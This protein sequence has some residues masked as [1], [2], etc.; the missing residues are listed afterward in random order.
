MLLRAI[1]SHY[2]RHPAQLAALWLILVLATALWTAVWTLTQ[3]ARD[4]MMAGEA[5]LGAGQQVIRSDGRPVSVDDFVS[6]RRLGLC[7]VPWLEVASAEARGRLVGID[8]LAM[9]CATGQGIAAGS[10]DSGERQLELDGR[11]FVDIRRAAELARAG[12]PSTFRL[13]YHGPG[14]HLADQLPGHVPADRVAGWQLRPNP[15]G[16]TTGGLA[17]SFLLNLDA[18]CVLVILVTAL[19]IRSVYTLGLAQ[20]RD[21]FALLERYGVPGSRVRRHLLTEL[22]LLGLLG[23]M[24]GFG[25]GLWLANLLAGGFEAALGGLFET[26]LLTTGNGL[27]SLGVVL[28][29]MLLVVFWCG[30][31]LL[32]GERKRRW[33][34]PVTSGVATSVL[35]L[36]GG[37]LVLASDELSWLFAG[38]GLLLAGIG[39]LTPRVLDQ[40]GGTSGGNPLALW[41]R[42]ETAVLI[43][44]LALPLV[45][46]QFAAATVIAVQALVTTFED[47]FLEWLDQRLAGDLYVEVPEGQQV[48]AVRDLLEGHGA[49]ANWYPTVTGEGMAGRGGSP[50]VGVDVRGTNPASALIRQWSLLEAGPDPWDSLRDQ[51]VM[52]NEQLALRLDLAP[53]DRLMLQLAGQKHPA[54]VAGIYADYGSPAGEVLLDAASLPAA[55]VAGFRSVVIELADDAGASGR[56]SLESAMALA[57]GV[58]AL[59]VRDN[60]TIRTFAIRLFDQTFRLTRAISVLTLGLAA[61]SLLLTGWVVL[62]SRVWY[63]HLLSV[64]GLTDR[65]RYCQIVRLMLGLLGRV[66]LMALPVGVLLTWILVA[67]INP[68]AFGWA[69]PMAVYPGYWLQLLLLL[70]IM[71]WLAAWLA[72]RG[73]VRAPRAAPA[74]QPGG[75]R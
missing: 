51:G 18:L 7:V 30:L 49:V 54:Q 47:T 2:R 26:S 22:V 29:V 71:G 50:S 37:A 56:A 39:L 24:P 10:G 66:W 68:V 1:L 23:A 38:T 59:V 19:L 74:A 13:L 62:R 5:Q 15:G 73:Q 27:F 36:A 46:L 70:A 17:D 60:A 53:G 69:L 14:N 33:A 41:S 40:G 6:L 48:A 43:R 64:W 21:S 44:R 3:Q 28:L 63:Y 20:R 55:F 61:T 65:Q 52:V 45:A 72:A 4:S 67:R 25:L 42:R 12:Q 32:R 8:P 75:E 31:D 11:P 34:G 58:P 35:L 9:G 16:L 57:W